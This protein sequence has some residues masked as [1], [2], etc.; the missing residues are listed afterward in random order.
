MTVIY[1]GGDLFIE[2]YEES[3]C[4]EEASF[5]VARKVN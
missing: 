2:H 1:V 5:K 4:G 3:S